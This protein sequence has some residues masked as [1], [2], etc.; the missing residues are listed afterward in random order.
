MNKYEVFFT[1]R[2]KK[3][4]REAAILVECQTEAEAAM[5]AAFY[6]RMVFDRKARIKEIKE[7]ININK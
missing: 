5:A 6:C 1:Y 3:E 2:M 7:R 4:T